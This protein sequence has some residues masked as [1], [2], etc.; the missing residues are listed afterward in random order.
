M[1]WL[2]KKERESISYRMTV[3]SLP[4]AL[5]WLL[6]CAYI[7]LFW[8]LRRLFSCFLVGA[9]H[10]GASHLL[11]PC[12]PA[13]AGAGSR[14]VRVVQVTPHHGWGLSVGAARMP[15]Q[16]PVNEGVHAYTRG[17]TRH[18]VWQPTWEI[19][20]TGEY[21]YCHHIYEK[22]ATV[23]KQLVFVGFSRRLFIW[24]NLLGVCQI[25]GYKFNDLSAAMLTEAFPQRFHYSDLWYIQYVQ[26]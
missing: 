24:W 21:N 2:K 15:T 26:Y 19:L 6:F 22:M 11:P 3:A 18:H 5:T 8:I 14:P 17:T 13:H 16:G 25:I 4:N 20:H 23:I 1:L 10:A 12:P 7:S 9:C